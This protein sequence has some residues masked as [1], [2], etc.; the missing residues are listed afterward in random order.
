MTRIVASVLVFIIGLSACTKHV[1]TPEE[2]RAALLK[3]LHP[4]FVQSSVPKNRVDDFY[5]IV[6]A[7][8]RDRSDSE[9]VIAL[10]FS[11]AD[12]AVLSFSDGGPH[13]GGTVTLKKRGD[14]WSV[15]QKAWFV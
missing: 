10:E 6:A 2:E 7:F 12:E 8:A 4:K 9:F 13:G 3:L 1:S 15:R 11:T 14:K 5:Q